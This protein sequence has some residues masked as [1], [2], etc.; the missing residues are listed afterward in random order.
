LNADTLAPQVTPGANASAAQRFDFVKPR[1]HIVSNAEE[2][3]EE[4]EF[5]A[6]DAFDELGEESEDEIEARLEGTH[7]RN[8]APFT[9]FPGKSGNALRGVP[10]QGKNDSSFGGRQHITPTGRSA[11]GIKR[12]TLKQIRDDMPPTPRGCEWRRSDEGWNLWRYWSEQD[13]AGKRRIKKTRYTG[14][15]SHDAW[16]IMKEYNHEAFL[17][18]VGQRL[19]RHGRG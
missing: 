14:H 16:Q 4:G 2:S 17:S 18:I 19:R 9:P 6:F 12:R 13:E 7:G 15:L 3:D 11:P 8:V 5:D 1:L 10:S